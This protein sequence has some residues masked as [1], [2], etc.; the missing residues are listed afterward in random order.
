MASE[1]AAAIALKAVRRAGWWGTMVTAAAVAAPTA[2]F[3]ASRVLRSSGGESWADVE[4]TT[5]D[6]LTM[7][8]LMLKKSVA[9]VTFFE[10]DVDVAQQVGHRGVRARGVGLL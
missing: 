8:T 9:T 7:D 2:A 10:G 5:A 3:L 4:T 6:L 1:S